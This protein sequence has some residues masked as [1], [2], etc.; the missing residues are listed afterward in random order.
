MNKMTYDDGCWREKEKEKEKDEDE[1][2][3]KTRNVLDSIEKSEKLICGCLNWQDYIL[4]G[5]LIST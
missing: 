4:I 5:E 2:D 1:K 3:L